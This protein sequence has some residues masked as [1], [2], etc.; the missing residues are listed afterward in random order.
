M[1]EQTPANAELEI[2][3]LLKENAELRERIG[4]GHDRDLLRERLAELSQ[5][6]E[7]VNAIA[8]TFGFGQGEL[9]D[10]LAGCLRRG[11]E[12]MDERL[13]E[14]DRLKDQL[15]SNDELYIAAQTAL[16]A[17]TRELE[18]VLSVIQTTPSGYLAIGAINR[19]L[20]AGAGRGGV[21]DKPQDSR[22]AGGAD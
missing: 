20:G 8:R 5:T 19:P 21:E 14:V 9:D 13:A 16:A 1:E 6:V 22:L 4:R 17:K 2:D 11:I 12:R 18:E 10:D 7:R 3:R 15:A